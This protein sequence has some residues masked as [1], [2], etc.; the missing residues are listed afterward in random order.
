MERGILMGTEV[1][2]KDNFDSYVFHEGTN[3]R[4]YSYF[5]QHPAKDDKGQDCIVFRV[6]APRAKNVSV[7]GDFNNWQENTAIPMQIIDG[8]G[9]IWEGYGYGLKTYDT[10]KYRVEGADGRVI[11]KSDPFG[12]HMETRP[13]NGSKIYDINGYAWHD[14]KWMDKRAQMVP[15]RS[16]MNIY[17]VHLGS[18]RVH[19]NGDFYDYVTYAQE[20][21]KYVKE[22]GY[23]HIEVMPLSEYPF[24]GSW[25]YQVTGYFAPTSRYGTP[26]DLM[27]FVDICHQHGIGVIM[28][29]VPAHFPKDEN[30]LSLFD[31]LPLYEYEDPRKGEH[32]EWGTKVFD[33]VRPEVVSFLISSAMYWLD[34]YHVDGLRVDAVASMLYLDYFRKDGEWIANQYGGREN[35]EAVKFLQVL[36]SAV[37]KEHPGALM[38]AEESTAWPLVTKPVEDGGLGFNFKWNMGWMNDMLHYVQ[39]DPYF[40]RDHHNNITFSLTYAFSEN[41]VLPLS[42]DEVVHGKKSLL[43][44][45]PGEY[46]EKFAG[47]RAFYG[48]MMGHPGKKLLFMGGEFGQ[49]IEWDYHKQLDWFLLGYN[50]HQKLHD[51]VKALNK[52]YLKHPPMYEQD[53]SWDGFKWICY[54]D[55]TQNIVSFRRI[56]RNGKEVICVV[57]FAPVRRDHY[58]IGAPEDAY[59]VEALNSDDTRFGGTGVTNEGWISAEEIPM[60]GYP[61]SIEL[62]IP[63][64]AAVFFTMRPKKRQKKE[65]PKDTEA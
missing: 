65:L 9:G 13:A 15:Y 7:I 34:M 40:R 53:D 59:Y 4:A 12:F 19:D 8:D 43:D 58:R 61:Q 1:K 42:H 52:F 50:M 35:L 21:C 64:L 62:T 49:F 33:Y 41:Y 6:W 47:L 10:Y 36:N 25:G 60:H 54:D 51:Y 44:K 14:A 32:Y 18:W 22:M 16:P 57:N 24:E 26:K 3:Y 45:Q 38:I 55:N 39:L 46:L 29:W 30:G 31:G 23:T 20:L 63:P 17:E 11:L 2:R 5:G 48:Y 56:D 37:F 28:D 27:K